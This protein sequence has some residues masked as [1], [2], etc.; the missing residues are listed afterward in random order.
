[1][2]PPPAAASATS[3]FTLGT[4]H[5]WGYWRFATG[6]APNAENSSSTMANI[7]RHRRLEVP[8]CKSLRLRRTKWSWTGWMTL[9]GKS[10]RIAGKSKG[11][12]ES[13]LSHA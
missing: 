3:I 12:N 9:W 4:I 6:G 2:S 8:Q 7:L 10:R 11:S 5:S 1:V 13:A